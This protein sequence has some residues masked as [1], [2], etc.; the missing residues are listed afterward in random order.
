M[1]VKSNVESLPAITTVILWFI[2]GIGLL[3]NFSK[4]KNYL[5]LDGNAGYVDNH[6]ISWL[7]WSNWAN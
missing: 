7:M 4:K 5:G 1:M 2:T 6:V 3:L